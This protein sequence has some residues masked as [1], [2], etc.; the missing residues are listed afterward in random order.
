MIDSK[1]TKRSVF[2][3][4][5]HEL[6]VHNFKGCEMHQDH[7]EFVAKPGRVPYV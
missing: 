4:S 7:I 3:P 1:P 6:A 2:A 5:V